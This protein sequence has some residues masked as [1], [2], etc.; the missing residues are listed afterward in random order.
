MATITTSGYLDD[1]ARSAGEAIT[2]Q[3][4]AKFTIRTD[5]RWHAN[6][7]ASM[8]GSLGMIDIQE[9]N[10][11]IDGTKVRWLAY[12]TGSGNVPAVGTSI[13]QGGVSASYLLGV[14]P[15]LVSA[16]TA[17]GAAMPASG[18]LKFREVTGAF[19]VGALTGIGA[20]ATGSDVTG[21]IEVVRDKNT[22]LTGS[23]L[24][25][26]YTC[27]GDW[28][29]LDNTNGSRG[30]QIQTPTNGG[31]NGT[32][33][34]AVQIETSSGSGVYEW[35]P[36]IKGPALGWAN[37]KMTTD[38]RAKFVEAMD[39]GIVR[40]GS[41]GT[42]NIGYLPSSGCKVRIP[43]IIGRSCVNTTRATNAAPDATLGNRPRVANCRSTKINLNKLI[44]DWYMYLESAG[45]TYY[46]FVASSDNWTFSCFGLVTMEDSCNGCLSSTAT[47]ATGAT[48]PPF[49]AIFRRCKVVRAD[50]ASNAAPFSWTNAPSLTLEDCYFYA[51]VGA[52]TRNT[53][54]Y[55]NIY[56]TDNI[57]INNIYLH[58]NVG[59]QINTCSNALVDGVDYIDN[60]VGNTNTAQGIQAIVLSA[61]KNVKIENFSIGMNNTIANCHPYYAIA[62][63]YGNLFEN[64]VFRN[65]GTKA[66][67]VVIS[68]TNPTQYI[69]RSGAADQK[70]TWQRCFFSSSN[71]AWFQTGLKECLL[72]NCASTNGASY[73]AN[74]F[75]TKLRGFGQTI[76]VNRY[77]NCYNNSWHDCFTSDTTG[78]VVLMF[79]PPI[80]EELN[81]VT[82]SGTPLFDAYGQFIN[83]SFNDSIEWE[84]P[85]FV[86]G[87]TSFQNVNPTITGTNISTNMTLKYKI[88]INDG[89]GWSSI[90]KDLTGANLS[91]ETISSS[92][93]FKLKIQ[94]IV[95]I[96]ASNNVITNIHI[97]TNSTALAQGTD[98]YPMDYL[99][100]TYNGY[101]S[102]T[103]LQ[104]WDVD[105]SIEIYN[106]VPSATTYLVSLPITVA[107][108][109]TMRVRIRAMYVDGDEAKNFY[110]ATDIY[111]HSWYNSLDGIARQIDLEDDAVYNENAVDGST[112]TGVTIDD[113]NLLVNINDGDN[114][115]SWA[116]IYAYE[117]YWL[118]TEAGIR[119]EGRF[120]EA[121][122]PVNYTIYGFK[123]K[124]ISDPSVP[125][126]ITGGYGVDSVT[127]KSITLVDSTGGTIFNSPDHIVK[128][129]PEITAADVWANGTRT[130]TAIGS[131]GIA[132][133][134]SLITAEDVWSATTRELTGIGTSGI[135]AETSLI[136]ASDVWSNPTRELT[137]IGASG[138]AAETSLIEASDVWSS[139]IE[140]PYTA[141]DILKILSAFAAGKTTIT[142]IAPGE[143]TVIFRDINDTR[144]TITA[145]MDENERATIVIDV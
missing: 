45:E 92:L 131:S 44:S 116:E 78:K 93:G 71:T 48:Y 118:T 111:T 49:P 18:F 16:P 64:V 37:T 30:Q 127:G 14:W 1:A 38:A 40:I 89:N 143:A 24:G 72:E 17:V 59:L 6:S 31:G 124:N 55:V 98:L 28:F 128:Y 2:I 70:I 53:N 134:T 73:N 8:T 102:G 20:N 23:N 140:G 91:S 87:H 138:I 96:A 114:T 4:N 22:Y 139:I 106:G 61:D 107:E 50:T 97:P 10:F 7:P 126:E 63:T 9:G 137:G 65:W 82:I 79:N 130:L 80:E 113:D 41:D 110:E 21:W 103:R 76:S 58:G 66:N 26:G 123:I 42:N 85:Y 83:R 121:V 74:Y 3:S 129:K 99:N 132:A 142:P 25:D 100:I 62:T 109:A 77:Q 35:Y 11:H 125:L 12:D 46:S 81:Y 54:L 34:P 32:L 56:L 5:T 86:L 135:A 36:A 33:I 145:S 115:I 95:T 51:A 75:H 29:Y 60:L 112:V 108:G 90:W 117:S 105:N 88:D 104:V 122:D 13:T 119:D 94:L 57:I 19:T 27:E 43:N 15:D 39:N 69:H 141:Q 84:C 120:I 68:S 144:D 67:P 47:V 136:D 101:P 52:A 133:E